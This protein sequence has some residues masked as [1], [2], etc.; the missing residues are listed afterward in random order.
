MYV[1]LQLPIM[2]SFNEYIR[3]DERFVNL[4]PRHEEEKHK[5]KHEIFN[6]LQKSYADQGGIHGS[7]FKDPDDMVKHIP[8]WKI[9]KKDG[10]ITSV[11]MYKDSQGR[12]RVAVASNGSEEGKKALGNMMSDDLKRSR[13]HGEVSGKSLSFMKKHIN[14]SDHAHTY[15][16]AKKY[17]S[18]K[19]DEVRKPPEDDAEVK[20]HPELKD[21]FYQRKIGDQW[22]TKVLLGRGDN[23]IT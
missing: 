11:S 3:L 16:E 7:G 17:H 8:F 4:L 20:R 1:Q 23:P 5:H 12:K 14:V 6:M 13:S 15:E 10:K 9:H 2:I 21:H 19:G 18:V 22:H